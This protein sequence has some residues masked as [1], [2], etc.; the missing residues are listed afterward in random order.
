MAGNTTTAIWVVANVSCMSGS[1]LFTTRTSTFPSGLTAVAAVVANVS[2][3]Y[4]YWIGCIQP[5]SQAA[6]NY[7]WSWID[8]T[9]ATN[10]LSNTTANAQGYGAWRTAQPE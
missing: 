4:T 7:G 10:L 8:G 1:H 9:N 5:T 2:N 6:R 3:V